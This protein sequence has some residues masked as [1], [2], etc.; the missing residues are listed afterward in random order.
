MVLRIVEI[1]VGVVGLGDFFGHVM[2]AV[3]GVLTTVT[4]WWAC[5]MESYGVDK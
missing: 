5:E 4:R 3:L 1:G 2:G